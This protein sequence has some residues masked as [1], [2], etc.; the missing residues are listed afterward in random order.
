MELNAVQEMDK[1]ATH[2][3]HLLDK[4]QPTQMSVNKKMDHGQSQEQAVESSSD[5]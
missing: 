5:H 4:L 3:N 2:N 1:E